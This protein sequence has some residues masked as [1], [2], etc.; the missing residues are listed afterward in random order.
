M[1]N[2]FFSKWA[3]ACTFL[4]LVSSCTKDQLV[5]SNS[6]DSAAQGQN[7]PH[8]NQA[9]IGYMV[10]VDPVTHK[11][12]LYK[13]STF[14]PTNVNMNL[15]G[16]FA[17][18]GTTVTYANG[19]ACAGNDFWICTSPLSNFPNR[20]LRF[21]GALVL[22]SS[23]PL[24]NVNVAYIEFRA[25]GQLLALDAV[26]KRINQITV[27]TGLCTA[28]GPVITPPAGYTLSGLADYT[29]SATGLQ[30]VGVGFL[31]NNAATDDGIYGVNIGTL[32]FPIVVKNKFV[33]SSPLAIQYQA[34]NKGFFAA[35][36]LA[37][38]TWYFD[39]LFSLSAPPIPTV[40]PNTLGITDM[41]ETL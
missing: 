11:S 4:T 22:I 33:P 38:N 31:D 30:E 6:A 34:A 16:A 41:S 13:G 35:P 5:T 1:K 25:T 24:S 18:G 23:V 32:A 14:I 26:A 37:L 20:L 19:L 28:I 2:L 36:N 8:R 29:N 15:V 9:G 40:V 21:S 27:G 17:I 3:L 7:V 10:N 39:P 12:F